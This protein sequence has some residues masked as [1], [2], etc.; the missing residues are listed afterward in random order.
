M[1]NHW[2]YW[3]QINIY[4]SIVL[5]LFL[6]LFCQCMLF[7]LFWGQSTLS[8]MQKTGQFLWLLH[9]HQENQRSSFFVRTSHNWFIYELI[10]L[11]FRPSVSWAE[12]ISSRSLQS[13]LE[14]DELAGLNKDLLLVNDPRGR[15]VELSLSKSR[16]S[17]SLPNNIQC[18]Y[19]YWKLMPQQL[20][21]IKPFFSI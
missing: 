4:F 17:L 15:E 16:I 6:L 14:F 10:S 7:Y 3:C 20:I 11:W 5:L 9:F 19:L 12:P 18:Q 13:F 21:L 2:S 8:L 1:P